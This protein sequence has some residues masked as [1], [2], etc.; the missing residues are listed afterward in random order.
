MNG[1]TSNSKYDMR[2]QD[3][4][5]S[6]EELLKRSKNVH[7][8]SEETITSDEELLQEAPQLNRN[9]TAATMNATKTTTK[10]DSVKRLR[11]R[12]TVPCMVEEE[13]RI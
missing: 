9:G 10:R 12:F 6:D 2:N 1:V 5:E 11:Q 8:V 13:V 7:Q 3:K 4:T